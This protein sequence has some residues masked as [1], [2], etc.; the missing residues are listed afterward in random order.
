MLKIIENDPWLTPF[1]NAIDGR[2]LRARDK[3]RE[4][5][6]GDGASLSGFA[7]GYLYFGL[8]KISGGWVFREWAPNA[9]GI[10]LIGDFSG[11]IEKDEFRLERI[12]NSGVW[13]VELPVGAI[14]HSQ[15]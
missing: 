14:H 13:Q 3:E 4:L 10:C 9:T 1:R 12:D 8:H 6:G 15:H 5:T 11:W 7:S 2:H